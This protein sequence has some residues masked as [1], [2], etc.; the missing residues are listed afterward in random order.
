MYVVFDYC[1]S[2]ST[3]PLLLLQAGDDPLQLAPFLPLYGLQDLRWA[4]WLTAGGAL[5]SQGLTVLKDEGV[6][7]IPVGVERAAPSDD[8]KHLANIRSVKDG[9]IC[10]CLIADQLNEK[11]LFSFLLQ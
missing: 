11:R 5:P 7:V 9:G 3:A 6:L 1:A 2:L 4:L 10:H 8:S